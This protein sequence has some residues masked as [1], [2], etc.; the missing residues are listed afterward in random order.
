MANNTEQMLIN[1]VVI[2]Q[3]SKRESKNSVNPP[4][5]NNACSDLD[6]DT[7]DALQKRLTNA[8]GNNSHSMKMEIKD[9]GEESVFQHITKFWLTDENDELFIELSQKLTKLLADAQDSMRIPG[10]V[11]VILRGTV[12]EFNKDFIAIIKAEKHDGFNITEK[13]G[14]N[15][16]EYFNNLLLTP[17]QKLHKIGYFVNNAVRGRNIEKKD[18]EAYVFDSNTSEN[19][20]A[21]HAAYFYNKFL[22]LEF[23]RDADLI[24]NKFYLNTRDFVNVCSNLNTENK[25][26]IQSE[27]RNYIESQSIRV[28]NPND[29]IRTVVSD[30]SIIDAY[31]SFIEEQDIP[32]QDTRKDIKLVVKALKERKISFQNKIKLLGPTKEFY[33][34]VKIVENDNGDTVITIKGKYINE[35]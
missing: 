10:G 12:T 1:K 34:N 8:L 4:V 24:T 9:V 23:R 2:H 3:I 5:Y 11:I 26:L 19:S 32:L 18:V 7:I 16:L 30:G 35:K 13:D 20:L 17:Q 29:F 21:A 31:L 15:L 22:G 28:I 27:L 33:E 6:N 14:K 25:I